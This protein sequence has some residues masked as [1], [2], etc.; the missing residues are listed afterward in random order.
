MNIYTLYK[1]PNLLIGAAEV[2]SKG[3]TFIIMP[4]SGLFLA[5]SDFILWALIFPTIQILSSALSFGLPTFLL[6]NYAVGNVCNKKGNAQIFLSFLI[7]LVASLFVFLIFKGVGYDNPLVNWTIYLLLITSSFLLII[8]TKYQAEKNGIKFLSQTIVWR[9]IFAILLPIIYFLK[10]K[11]SL[12]L[13][14]GLLLL[15]QVILVVIAV[16][17]E[18]LPVRFE[19]DLL[20]QKRAFKFGFPLFLAGVLQYVIYMN[21]RYFIFEMGVEAESY[22]FSIIQSI[23][24][25]LNLLLAVFVRV[26][27]PHFFAFL[28]GKKSIES[29]YVYK[30]ILFPFFEI[31]IIVIFLCLIAFSSLNQTSFDDYIFVVAP[32]L[33]FGEFL[34]FIQIFV[35]NDL[36][37]SGRT[38]TFLVINMVLATLSFLLGYVLVNKFGIYGGQLVLH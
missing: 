6:R 9:V 21:G 3:A 4:L 5:T 11:A 10:A 17:Q 30:T 18:C 12:D 36:M 7:V 38:L 35:I 15:I 33:I 13:L 25:A 2:F 8:Q 31:M 24:G 14:L 20:E 27:V 19:F 22:V 28:S 29:L 34:F 26:Y 16:Y 23:V 37:Y 32:I 1:T